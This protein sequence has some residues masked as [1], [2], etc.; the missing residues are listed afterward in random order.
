MSQ[1]RPNGRALAAVIPAPASVRAAIYTRVSTDSGLDQEFN[2][3]MAQREAAE[4]YV[5]SQ[6]AKGWIALSERYD[7]G[8]FSGA[9]AHRPALKRLLA[10]VEADKIDCI[11]VYK[12]DRMSRSTLDFL[13]IL[14][15]LE[16]RGVGMVSV[17]QQFDT[18]SPVGRMTMNVLLSFGQF[19]REVIAERTRDKMSAARRRGRWTGG[20]PPLGFD[21]VP[22]G[23]KIV[24]NPTEAE[25]V[26]AIFDLYLER[27]SLVA[28]SQE[29]NR[30]GWRR[31]SWTTKTGV[32]REGG[33]WDAP[34]L[35][36]L[37]RDP[38]YAGLQK[39][40]GETFPGEH[41]GIVPKTVFEKVQKIMKENRR[42]GGAPVRNRHAGLLRGL[43]RCGACDA[44]MVHT[45]T[46][47]GPRLHRY[48]RC[49]RG[50]KRG[51]ATCPTKAIR[52][53]EIE[54]FVV[55]QIGKIG[56][57]PDLQKATFRQALS[58]LAANRR[59]LRAEAK[60]LE[61]ELKQARREVE[62][63][64]SAVTDAD[65]G[66]RDAILDRL[67]KAQDHLATVE[68]RLT[69]VRAHQEALDGQKVDEADLR[70]TLE[71]FDPI[72]RALLT[73]ERERVLNLLLDRVVYDAA[74]EQ[75]SIEFRLPG[76]ARF[77]GEVGE[78]AAK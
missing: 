74:T 54:A 56:A 69:E 72:W 8:G 10:D 30:R 57:D 14:K 39:L 76:M 18:T 38:L 71:A 49:S 1:A 2:S 11:V 46:R 59:V 35:R 70:R 20:M 13:Q 31:K 58:Q 60:R 17:S 67:G 63:L 33:Q 51:M 64:L 77:A 5:A 28:V 61:P 24:P 15:F 78:G 19:E 73:P 62:R 40:R 34:T 36:R 12:F 53:D 29:L 68:A 21:V 16:E 42:T 75:M 48:Y 26:R 44:A 65:G 45:W 4:A 7:D 37:L 27:A 66:A 6:K 9:N 52:A 22:E 25:Q 55:Q 47:R 23:G 41:K 3:L 43:L 32:Q 50:E